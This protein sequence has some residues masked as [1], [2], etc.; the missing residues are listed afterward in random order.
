MLGMKQ[1]L[2]LAI[3]LSVLFS[4]GTPKAQ[5]EPSIPT[6]LRQNWCLP[7]CRAPEQMLFFGKGQLLTFADRTV[8]TVPLQKIRK[9]KD[10][11]LIE[12][13]SG[14]WVAQIAEDGVLTIAAV[15]PGIFSGSVEPEWSTLPFD[16]RDEYM[17]CV[18]LPPNNATV[19]TF[20][21]YHQPLGS[22]DR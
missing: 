6:E 22:N 3:I 7:D 18:E 14:T 4:L 16:Q 5:A 20:R 21:A 2:N 9:I 13:L 19:Q 15:H 11:W 12:T 1:L 17:N 10:Y 8:S